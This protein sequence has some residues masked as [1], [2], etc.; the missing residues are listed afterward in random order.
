L[1]RIALPVVLLAGALAAPLSAAL[2]DPPHVDI[3]F[4]GEHLPEAAQD[5][6]FHALPWSSGEPPA[7]RWHIL[8]GA[9]YSSARV[10]FLEESGVLGSI[11]LERGFRDGRALTLFAFHDAFSVGGEGGGQVLSAG[12]AAGVPLDLPAHA[13]FTAPRGDF[14]HWGAGAVWSWPIGT[15]ER[16]RAQLGMMVGRLVLRG[17]RV[18]YELLDG[19][20]AGARGTL[21]QSGAATFATPFAGIGRAI[22]LGRSFVL[23]VRSLGGV[24]LPPGD[25]DG[26]LSGPGFDVS[27]RDQGGRPGKIGDGFL[28]LAVGLGH[29]R[30]GLELDLG[31]AATYPLFER[32]THEGVDSALFLHLVW[33][34]R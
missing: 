7:G 22:P 19:A 9:G 15:R 2:P 14:L 5:A 27:S 17:Y 4:L 29:S 6:R 18:D 11:G 33:R 10:E 28:A 34:G 13:R 21:D 31:S 3:R 8:A 23:A 26:R 12:F 1:R 32:V 24:P 30:S 25:F 20:D 16:W